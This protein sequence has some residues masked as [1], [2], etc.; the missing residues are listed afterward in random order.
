[1]EGSQRAALQSCFSAQYSPTQA[2]GLRLQPISEDRGGGRFCADGGSPTTPIGVGHAFA[3]QE[4]SV[5]LRDVSSFFVR[6]FA[7]GKNDHGRPR[8]PLY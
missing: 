2:P 4:T 8:I 1:M 6:F 5:R 7:E 3:A